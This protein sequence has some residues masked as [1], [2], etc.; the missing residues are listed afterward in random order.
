MIRPTLSQER[1]LW[2][3]GARHV[4][5][6][7]EVGVGPLCA[8]VVAAAVQLPPGV[9]AADL[10]G[11]RDSKTI[12]HARARERLAEQIH[13]VATRV[14][15]GAASPREIDRLN[16]RGATALAM[17]RA[18][19]RLGTYDHALLDGRPLPGLGPDR[20][21]FLVDG[22][23]HC[24]SIACASIIA[25]V[26][27]DRLMRLLAARYP[28]YGWERNAGYA[29]ADH[30]AALRRYGPTPH[31]RQRYRPVVQAELLLFESSSAPPATP[32]Q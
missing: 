28:E 27:R 23:A 16:V 4:V 12:V 2:E 30:L 9:D 18:L 15:V 19:E 26:T 11:V 14:V 21:T 20:H 25:K 8:A 17:R 7:D 3:A 5:G 10:A 1:A 32:C 24:L 6:V 13:R 22:D 31:H 29:T